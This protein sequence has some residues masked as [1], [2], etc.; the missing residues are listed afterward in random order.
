MLKG[1]IYK[2]VDNGYN[3]MYIGSTTKSLSQRMAQHRYNYKS[4]Q[5]NI[6]VYKIFDKYGV[7]NCKIELIEEFYYINREYLLKKEGEHIKNNNCI[8]KIIHSRTPIEY[9][10]EYREKNKEKI[11][12]D[13][14][15]NDEYYKNYMKEYRERNKEKIKEY[16][17]EY[18]KNKI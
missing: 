5:N 9:M 14:E 7:E 16:Q 15:I 18:R 8:N 2:I 1:K 12:D 3:D 17:K 4:Q 6:T 11:K 13:R 10:K